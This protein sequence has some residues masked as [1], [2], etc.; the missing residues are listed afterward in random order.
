MKGR[1]NEWEKERERREA[2]EEKERR[3]IKKEE[4]DRMGAGEECI[5]E[6]QEE[7]EK[8]NQ[9]RG[10][11]MG[12]ART[13]GWEENKRGWWGE[14]RWRRMCGGQNGGGSGTTHPEGRLK[15]GLSQ[16]TSTEEEAMR[17]T[18]KRGR[19]MCVMEGGRQM[20]G[21]PEATDA[22]EREW[23]EDGKEGG[24]QTLSEGL[25]DI[26]TSKLVPSAGGTTEGW[27]GSWL[28]RE[29]EGLEERGEE[30][31]DTDGGGAEL[32]WGGGGEAHRS[33]RR[34]EWDEAG[35]EQFEMEEEEQRE[36]GSAVTTGEDN[37]G[38]IMEGGQGERGK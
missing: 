34:R 6:T 35:W 29:M 2:K 21:A 11:K 14:K 22:E 19:R 33:K 8:W 36:T 10:E 37:H 12:A 25:S 27:R 7:R 13:R 17:H 18:G 32:Y 1:R 20:E 38:E 3:R 4:E 24:T 5:W 26:G 15:R 30:V 9:W 23:E 28:V 16:I 31:P